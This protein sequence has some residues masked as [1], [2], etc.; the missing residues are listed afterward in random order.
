LFWI[1]IKECCA[2]AANDPNINIKI[3]ISLAI[4]SETVREKVLKMTQKKLLML[5]TIAPWYKNLNKSMSK[6]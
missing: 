4:A 5:G 6:P 3:S 2:D 1:P